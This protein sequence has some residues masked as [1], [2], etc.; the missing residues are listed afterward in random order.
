MVKEEFEALAEGESIFK[1]SGPL[2][3]RQPVEEGKSDV[4]RRLDLI[5]RQI[6][7]MQDSIEAKKSE[8]DKIG[9]RVVE[10]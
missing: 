4:S 5:E 6:K 3:V 7:Q 9:E 8:K 10:M 1:L 2:L